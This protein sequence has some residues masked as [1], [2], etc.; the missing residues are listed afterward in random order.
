M[1]IETTGIV[2]VGMMGSG[3]T[4]VGMDIA[5]KLGRPFYDTDNLVR[6]LSGRTIQEAFD[7][8]GEAVFRRL[9]TKALTRIKKEKGAVVSTGGGVVTVE[10]NWPLMKTLG[11]VVYL[12]VPFER[13]AE[14]VARHRHERPLLAEDDWR[15][16]LKELLDTRSAEYKRA[17]FVIDVGDRDVSEV[18]D[19]VIAA[20][21]AK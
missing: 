17:D 1:S 14:R 8:Y 13:I 19:L 7:K 9:E 12:D 18:A 5:K 4:V 16:R 11:T 20:V 21:G 10:E 3:K 15:E 2:L 6:W